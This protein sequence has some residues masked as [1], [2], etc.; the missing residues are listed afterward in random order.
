MAGTF[1]SFNT[2]LTALRYN[3]VVM[4]TA[5]GNIANA[6]TEGYARRRVE[7]ATA[8]TAVNPAMWSR[9]QNTGDGVQVAG[10]TRMADPF[11]AARARIEHGNQHYLDLQASV[12]DRIESG[13]GEPSDNGVAAAMLKFR[14]AVQDLSNNPS[15]DAA[16]SQFL[17]SAQSL[18]ASINN[19][20]HNLQV[21]ASDQRAKLLST[22][23]Q[24]NTIA[25]DLAGVNNSIK[26]ARLN[27]TDAGT[28]Y[29]QRDLLGQQL[30]EL[31]GA[32]GTV[33]SDGGLDLSVNGVSLVTAGNCGNVPD[34]HG[35]H[36]DGRLRRQPGDLLD[37]RPDSR[38]H[39]RADRLQG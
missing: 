33:N 30:A 10:I 5:S 4:D 15:S 35:G 21:E 27:G 16:R 12:M 2:A 34:H 37:R 31:T 32:T 18:S 20:A 17:A 13:I 38:D 23:D 22:V 25:S 28:L 26:V 11:L 8:S 7:G 39:G 1:S 29:D 14:S 6:Q 3:Q 9:G 19:Q 24:V 36:A